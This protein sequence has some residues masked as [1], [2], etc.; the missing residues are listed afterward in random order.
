MNCE[1]DTKMDN[2][3]LP[4]C[5]TDIALPV[6]PKAKTYGE[7]LGIL[8][9]VYSEYCDK[10]YVYGTAVYD[11]ERPYK[12]LCHFIQQIKEQGVCSNSKYLN[13]FNSRLVS[14]L[15]KFG[16]SIIERVLSGYG[17]NEGS[18]YENRKKY[19]QFLIDELANR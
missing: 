2:N 11:F 12:Y 7:F 8:L 19:L 9:D 1:T 15:E 10:K 5:I 17:I 13:R 14:D 6:F 18:V 4:Q 3:Q 16:T